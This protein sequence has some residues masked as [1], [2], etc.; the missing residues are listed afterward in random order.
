MKLAYSIDKCKKW[1]YNENN[2]ILKERNKMKKILSIILVTVML[3]TMGFV[4]S[5]NPVGT[6]V[7]TALHTDIVV[8]INNYAIPSY[9]VNGQ[10][11]IVAEDLR[12]FCFNVVWDQNTRSLN[13]DRNYDTV[14]PHQMQ[15]SKG[16]PTG[17]K[18][19][20][21]LSTDIGVYANGMKINSYAMNGYTM[22]P[23]EEL[24][25]LG[26][27]DWND[28]E[29]A[30]YMTVEGMNTL[31]E[32]QFILKDIGMGTRT[33]PYA[34]SA[35]VTITYSKYSRDPSYQIQIK[36][37]KVIKGEA[38]DYLATKENQFNKLEDP[39]QQWIFF[40]FELSNIYSTAGE[41]S[42]LKASEVF[43]SKSFYEPSGTVLPVF[44]NAT[45]GDL[46]RAYSMYDVK[47]LPG[48]NSRV[49]VGF[50]TEKRI[51]DVLLKVPYNSGKNFTWIQ[52]NASNNVISSIDKLK[53]YM[54]IQEKQQN[55]NS[56]IKI[57]LKN[58]LPTTISSYNYSKKVEASARITSFEYNVSGTTVNMSFTGE[59]IYDIEGNGQSRTTKIGWKL[60]DGEGYVIDDGMAQST[61]IK[62]GE[63]F[64]NCND[65][66]FG[67]EP[68]IYTLEIMDIN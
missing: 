24:T 44:D 61:S 53:A 11:V 6:V 37:N 3:F 7:G 35:G 15:F 30:L 12:N 43:Y 39:S 42:E 18:F 26:K 36:C 55:T 46:L 32:P 64:K 2:Q 59:K 23:V 29:R 41:D 45:L 40:D 48:G 21:I 50:A 31:S 19:T 5:A 17:T 1:C 62:V 58:E 60:Y 16:Y 66:I 27:I 49:V 47:L 28:N 65:T 25:M 13:I 68:G 9:A 10:S 33:S 57:I 63:K 14:Q 8:Y 38:A 56:P 20:D 34:A 67:L 52:C 51:T 54:N 4:T 22:I